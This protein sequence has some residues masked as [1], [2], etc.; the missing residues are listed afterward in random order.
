M[1]IHHIHHHIHPDKDSTERLCRIETT[2]ETINVNLENIM[3]TLQDAQ[4]AQA[5]TDTK[6]DAIAADVTALL[7]K[8][9]AI[10][11]AGLTPEQQAA[12]DDIAAH[13]KAINDKL[14]AVDATVNP[15]PPNV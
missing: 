5:I 1:S 6:I 3:S 15:P 7:A 12:I 14:S 2:L 11:P 13:A 4:A 10:P 8:I 9:A